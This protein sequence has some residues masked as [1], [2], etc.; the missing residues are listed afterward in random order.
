MEHSLVIVESPAKAKTISRYL[1]SEYIVYS[2]VGHIRDLP[3]S[4]NSASKKGGKKT[5]SKK[6]SNKYGAMGLAPEEG[7]AADYQI[8]PGKEKVVKE[9]KSKAKGSQYIYLATDPDREGEAIAWHLSQVIG[10]DQERYIRVVFNEITKEAV[11]HAFVAREPGVIN[12]NMVYAQQAR[13]FLDR[14]VG[15]K[16]SPLLWKRIAR[17]LSAGRVQSVAVRLIVERE[18]EIA[19]FI[20]EEYWHIHADLTTPAGDAFRSEVIRYQGKK[21]R[22]GDEKAVKEHLKYLQK[23]HYQVLEFNKKERKQRP[24]PPFITSSLQQGA[25]LN[26]SFSVKRTMTLAQK[27]YEGGFITYMRTDS[28]QLSSSAITSCRA[29]IGKNYGQD[30]LPEKPQRYSNKASA[31]EAHEA[32]RPT[33]INLLPK[34]ITSLDNSAQK[35]YDLIRRRF[36]ACQMAPAVFWDTTV[37]IGVQSDLK[38]VATKPD[39]EFQAKGQVMS[40]DGF[41]KVQGKDVNSDNKLLPEIAENADLKLVTLEPSQHF[42]KPPARFNEASLVKDLEKLGIGRPS[43]YASIIS[44]IQDRGYVKLE[45]RRFFAEKIGTLV[46]HRL[47]KNF[48]D[49]LDYN[50]SASMENNLDGIANGE[51]NWL[52][53][54]DDFYAKFCQQ[55]EIA[56]GALNTSKTA[57]KNQKEASINPSAMASNSPTPTEVRCPKCDRLM[58]LRLATTG[59]F[60]SCTGYTSAKDSECKVTLDLRPVPPASEDIKDDQQVLTSPRCPRCESPT[61]SYFIDSKRKIDVCNRHPDCSGYILQEGNFDIAQPSTECN[62]CDGVMHLKRGRFGPY[63]SCDE[64]GNTRKAM[65]DGSPAPVRMDPIPLAD[66]KC[67]KV[68]DYFILREGGRGLFLAASNYP[69]HRETR[70]PQVQEIKPYI[71][72]LPEKYAYLAEAPE[73][74]PEGNP[75]GLRYSLTDEMHY[76]ATIIDGKP[77]KWQAHYQ[78][79]KWQATSKKPSSARKK[80]KKSSK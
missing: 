68:D 7:W 47:E 69:K 74:D 25:S 44:T 80:R 32:I 46:T 6:K 39:Y 36:L 63:Y 54:L 18:E 17:G 22:V 66:I 10:G 45:K 49:L 50:F 20:P 78:N 15:Y 55:L 1:G 2:C 19:K 61:D 29:Y 41:L 31:Q 14:V 64:C 24:R 27:L 57:Q 53:L 21:W 30:Y 3:T 56:D 5:T 62:K 12:Q 51:V 75:T 28:T 26:L 60:L 70:Q 4:G 48:H 16:L 11:Q 40:F 59:L 77:G 58:V 72:Q 38:L 23:A 8:V 34:Q 65:K 76:I 42:T 33:D 35:L 73:H 43:T 37:R 79:G 52:Q 13:R 9:L 71:A 67:S